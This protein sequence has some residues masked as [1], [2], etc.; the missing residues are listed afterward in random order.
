M[1]SGHLLFLAL[2]VRMRRQEIEWK[3]RRTA[4]GI[5]ERDMGK[6]GRD[7]KGKHAGKRRVQGL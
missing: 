5:K 7:G 6:R 2:C 1:A 4:G 3:G